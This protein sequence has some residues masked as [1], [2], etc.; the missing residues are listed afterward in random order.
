MED[1]SA[2]ATTSDCSASSAAECGVAAPPLLD[3]QGRATRELLVGF[4]SAGG[5]A[6]FEEIVRRYGA[7]VL[8]V[9]RQ[10]TR[11]RHDAED[12][13]QVVF[14]VLAERLRAG[15]TI[16]SL[17]A[18]LQQVARRAAIDI[19]RSRAR[20]SRRERVRASRQAECVPPPEGPAA[21]PGGELALIIRE[22][23][24]RVP[25]KYRVPLVLHYFGGM[26]HPEMARELGIKP[27]TLNVRLF[28]GRKMLGERL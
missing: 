17:G 2:G 15:E 4:R 18:W 5:Q 13:T 7:M 24:D 25:A 14:L 20:R 9:C 16:H 3:L 22:E 23:L 21:E 10:V 8:H 26:G 27:P 19:K 12:A 11:D 6:C 28:R 1:L